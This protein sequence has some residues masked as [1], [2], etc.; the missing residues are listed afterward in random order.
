RYPVFNGTK[1]KRVQIPIPI[2]MHNNT[3]YR[4]ALD[5]KG[6]RFRAFIEDQEIDSWNDDRLRAG[7]VGFFSETGE[8]ARVYWMRVSHNTDWLG[9][10]CGMI[11]GGAKQN[12][13][14]LWNPEGDSVR[15][16]LLNPEG[17]LDGGRIAYRRKGMPV[18]PFAAA[19]PQD[20]L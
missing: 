15:I 10:L 6:T 12:E 17:V 2:M 1:G 5:V 13:A 11:A 3:P 9:R 7:G 4:V 8:H 16:A 19:F 18:L 20:I 14:G